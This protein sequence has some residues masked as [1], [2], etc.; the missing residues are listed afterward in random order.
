MA[1]ADVDV[2]Q[3]K[4]KGLLEMRTGVSTDEAR[5]QASDLGKVELSDPNIDVLNAS[6]VTGNIQPEI[7]FRVD[8]EPVI[9]PD[10]RPDRNLTF[11]FC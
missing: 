9:K 1:E 4:I 2:F 8:V 6:A 7:V 11:R 10:T 3:A 5:I